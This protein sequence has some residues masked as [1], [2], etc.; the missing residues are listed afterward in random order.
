M[1]NFTF[2]VIT[3]FICL[4]VFSI[5]GSGIGLDKIY[6][7]LNK[8][9]T[10]PA[11]KSEPKI[12]QQQEVAIF[13]SYY[14]IDIP[15]NVVN[16]LDDSIVNLFSSMR[17]FSVKGYQFRFSSGNLEA[18]ISK[19]QELKDK[20]VT[21][22]LEFVDP[23]WGT[24]TFSPEQLEQLLNAYTIVIPNIR[25]FGVETRWYEGKTYY[26]VSMEISVKFFDPAEGILFSPI[27]IKASV[28]PST[29][30]RLVNLITGITPE[31]PTKEETIQMCIEEV[32]KELKYQLRKVEKFKLYTYINDKKDGSYYIELGKNF[33]VTPGLEL[34]ILKT[35]ELTIGNKTRQL[36]EIV[37]TVR[38]K[39]VEEDFSE[40][41]PI[42]GEPE[43]GDQVADA[44]LR[45]EALKIN[46]ELISYN[47]DRPIDRTLESYFNWNTNRGFV[48][49][50]SLL[51][52]SE[53]GFA[54]EGEGELGLVINSPL[55]LL[56]EG[57]LGYSLYFRNLKLRPFIGLT[58]SG[59][60]TYLGTFFIWTISLATFSI[61]GK[62]GADLQFLFS[63]NFG[64]SAE[65]GF[66]FTTP[67]WNY[68]IIQ[69]GDYT[70]GLFSSDLVPF[71]SF[72]GPYF[73]G[74]IFFRY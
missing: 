30:T 58:L 54:L 10:S 39:N 22:K 59:S 31:M 34:D 72:T 60:Y 38:V 36:T 1:K 28:D 9:D 17:R 23:K 8:K 51:F 25:G 33:D 19:L 63:K 69:P 44:L 24:I 61:G 13:P 37:G 6:V 4:F 68:F 32:T 55:T 48:P 11:K 35:K 74:N 70:T 64:I 2:V 14:S 16:R 62:V 65:G 71:L 21:S 26:V 42:F 20:E 73:G 27:E 56:L 43:V 15:P 41:I 52:N 49:Y 29:G 46:F 12:S 45:G 50:I 5:S 40:V 3:G 7:Q 57:T 53:I 67:V 47:Y 66:R 18:F